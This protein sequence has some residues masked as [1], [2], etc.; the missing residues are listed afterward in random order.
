MHATYPVLSQVSK[1]R[2]TK[3]SFV[4]LDARFIYTLGSISKSRSLTYQSS[5][6]H[7]LKV[8]TITKSEASSLN[9][10]TK[11][12]FVHGVVALQCQCNTSIYTSTAAHPFPWLLSLQ[13]VS[14][15]THLFT[16]PCFALPLPVPPPF[17]LP[18]ASKG[19]LWPSRLGL[20]PL[21][22]SLAIS[23]TL[24]NRH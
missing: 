22:S 4:H 14:P 7:M 2:G 15:V 3:V 5:P 6:S 13:P 24:K 16:F 18:P 23:I 10:E 17:H 20:T 8:Y 21:P 11:N 19:L 1:R 9:F 12:V